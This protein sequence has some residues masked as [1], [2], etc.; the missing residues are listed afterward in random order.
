MEIRPEPNFKKNLE[1][2]E[3]Y[4]LTFSIDAGERYDASGRFSLCVFEINGHNS[5]YMSH[6]Y[7]RS[8]VGVHKNWNSS[9]DERRLAIRKL[10]DA[11]SFLSINAYRALEKIILD[12]EVSGYSKWREEY[13]NQILGNEKL[14]D[15][16]VSSFVSVP[17]FSEANVNPAAFEILTRDKISLEESAIIPEHARL[18]VRKPD[19]NYPDDMEWVVKPRNGLQTRGVYKITELKLRARLRSNSYFYDANLSK[20]NLIQSYNRNARQYRILVDVKV[21]NGKVDSR[22]VNISA[23]VPVYGGTESIRYKLFGSL[24]RTSQEVL[25]YQ[26]EITASEKLVDDILV[27]VL[28][29]LRE[30]GTVSH[31]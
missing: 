25:L 10:E 23:G 29:F 5:G 11:Q 26:Q 1:S 7:N 4:D 31:T 8:S 20:E 6:S 16:I 15:A 14:I 18:E 22:N 2:K 24:T 27:N 17:I 3:D 19:V 13:R 9:L 30:S 21:R 12:P 28:N